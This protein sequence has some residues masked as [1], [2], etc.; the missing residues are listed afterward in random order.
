[1]V[2]FFL[3]KNRIVFRTNNQ[4]KQ[5]APRWQCQAVARFLLFFF[6]RSLLHQHGAQV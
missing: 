2:S 6:C 5:T 3:L 4:V 1:M